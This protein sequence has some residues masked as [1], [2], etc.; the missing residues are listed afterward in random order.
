MKN[1][2]LTIKIV[3]MCIKP[4]ITMTAICLLKAIWVL[5]IVHKIGISINLY[6]NYTL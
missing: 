5:I 1:Y 4:D 2:V 6:V 3:T